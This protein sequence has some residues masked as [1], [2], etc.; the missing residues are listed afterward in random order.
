MSKIR[1][2]VDLK[3]LENLDSNMK[4]MMEKNIGASIC[5]IININYLSMKM[6][7]K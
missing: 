3:E 7:E 5:Q 4:K 2:D 1:D 6:R